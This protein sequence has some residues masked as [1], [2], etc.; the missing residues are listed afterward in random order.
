MERIVYIPWLHM[1]QPLV[2]KNEKL[3]SNLQKMIESKNWNEKWNGLLI[4]RAYKNPAKYV[5]ELSSLGYKPKIMLD[6]SGILLESLNELSQNGFFDNLFVYKERIG[7]IIELYRRVLNEFPDSIEFA[8][9]AY[10]H[11]YFPATPIKDWELQIKEWRNVFK[12]IF[13]LKILRRV[14][15]FWLPEMGVPPEI[16]RQKELIKIVS[17][18]YDWI[19]LPIQSI[20]GYRQIPYEKVLQISFKPWIW[21]IDKEKIKVVFSLPKTFI[22]QQAGCDLKC[23]TERFEKAF[24]VWKEDKPALLIPTGD[25]ENGNVMMNEF[26][27]QT[28]LPFFKRGYPKVSS[29]LISE[30]LEKFYKKI[31]QKIEISS[32]GGSWIDHHEQWLVGSKRLEIIKEIEKISSIYHSLKNKSEEL[33]KLL[34]IA[35]TSCYVYW[36]IDYWFNQGKKAIQKFLSLI[37][38]LNI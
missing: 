6:F 21:Q 18:Y 13:G 19:I 38:K 9:S 22:D 20:K 30:F 24:E 2:W 32:V 7:N 25:G 10:S 28:F 8:G 11:C 34:L 12:K 3:I 31:D 14:K 29:Y 23:L 36:N 16:D 15:G 35:E 33:K 27:P 4:A 1:H 5:Y 17:K 26:F 37:K